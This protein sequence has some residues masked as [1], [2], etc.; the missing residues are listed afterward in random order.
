MPQSQKHSLW[1][2]LRPYCISALKENT[3]P[4]FLHSRNL[5]IGA[6]SAS[7]AYWCHRWAAQHAP[8]LLCSSSWQ[9]PCG[10]QPQRNNDLGDQ[11]KS[12]LCL[13]PALPHW[14][15][16]TQC[17]QNTL[18]TET[19]AA[20]TEAVLLHSTSQAVQFKQQLASLLKESSVTLQ[21]GVTRGPAVLPKY[22]ERQKKVAVKQQ[23]KIISLLSHKQKQ[24][25]RLGPSYGFSGGMSPSGLF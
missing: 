5:Y 21:N 7:P 12:H 25:W 3:D 11:V 15:I 2:G 18:N 22:D 6:D 23:I 4:F 24:K 8:L 10:S 9:L 1:G 13:R 16:Y 17:R 20:L 14:T 19:R